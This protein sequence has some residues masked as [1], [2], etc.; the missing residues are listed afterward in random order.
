MIKFWYIIE[1]AAK[2]ENNRFPIDA[3]MKPYF[4][5]IKLI[6]L[7]AI[8]APMAIPTTDIDIGKVAKDLTGLIWDPIIPL[9]NTVTGAAVKL[10]IW[11]NVKIRR[12]LFIV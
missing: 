8:I 2:I 11:L 3:E 9:K 7:V 1:Y 4:L 12:F 6:T 10:K 5:P